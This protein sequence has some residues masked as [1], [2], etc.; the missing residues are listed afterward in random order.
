MSAF[1][2]DPSVLTKDKLKSELAANNVPLP[3]IEFKKDVYVQMYLKNLTVLNRKSPLQYTF[4]SDEELAPVVS[5]KSRSGRKATRKT[6]KPRS[7]EKEITDT[8]LEPLEMYK[9]KS[10]PIVASTRNLYEKKLQKPLNQSPFENPSPQETAEV[11]ADTNQNGN[12]HS[13][14]YSDKEDEDNFVPEFEPDTVI[15]TPVRSRGKTLV[16]VRTSSRGNNKVEEKFAS[17]DQTPI[18]GGESVVEDILANEISTLTGISATSR[19][20][21][22]GAAGRPLKPSDYWLNESLLQHR[23]PAESHFH[24]EIFSQGGSPLTTSNALGRRRFLAVR[25]QLLFLIVVAVFFYYGY[26]KLN[27]EQVN[28]IKAFAYKV[29]FPLGI[30]SETAA[31]PSNKQ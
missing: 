31:E 8:G 9:V 13:D 1:L 3:S 20:P 6:D 7:E 23:L 30:S 14:Q 16:T 5:N 26:Q 21:I 10:G 28:A 25:F 2:E 19:R 24:S 4:S 18:K 17:G 29:S 15:M 11:K 27:A 12:T 22:R